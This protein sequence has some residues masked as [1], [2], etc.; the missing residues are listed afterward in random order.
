MELLEGAMINTKKPFQRRE[1]RT[2]SPPRCPNHKPS[3][4]DH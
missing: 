3:P 1:D 2:P 4:C